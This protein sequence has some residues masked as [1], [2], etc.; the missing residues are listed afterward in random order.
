MKRL[1]SLPRRTPSL[2]CLA[3]LGLCLL[4][5]A[6]TRVD[7]DARV[8]S[9]TY[10][11]AVL[12]LGPADKSETLKDGTKVAEWLTARGYSRGTMTSF[13]GQYY[14]YPWIHY[15]SEQPSPDYLI[16]LTFSPDGILRAW[17]KVLR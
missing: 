9:Y 16:R 1:L 13:G 14:G 2:F 17:R 15:Y 3:A 12:E 6:T 7:W 4:G 11:Q 5:C 8:G 10:D